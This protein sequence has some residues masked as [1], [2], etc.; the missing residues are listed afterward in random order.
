MGLVTLAGSLIGVMATLLYPILVKRF[1]VRLSAL[2]GFVAELLCLTL[3]LVDGVGQMFGNIVDQ[4]T[5]VI[6][7]L[8]GIT[9]ARFGLWVADMGVN[10]L[11]QT[12]SVS[13]PM[14]SSVQTSVN[15]M[16]ELVKFIVVLFVSS[17][18]QFYI[19]SLMSYASVLLGSF[20]FAIYV[21]KSPLKR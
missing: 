18:D 19:L 2:I 1:G 20:L 15:I 12:E 10:Q 17:V 13:P 14:V 11:I 3:C 16:M 5:G 6:L 21:I 7:L 8:S 9:T 4:K